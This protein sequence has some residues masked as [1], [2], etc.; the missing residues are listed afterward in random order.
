MNC[1]SIHAGRLEKLYVR[2][3]FASWA[4]IEVAVCLMCAVDVLSLIL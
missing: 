4:K 1:Y 3:P 2:A